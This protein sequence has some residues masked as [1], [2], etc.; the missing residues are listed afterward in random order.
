MPANPF[1][2]RRRDGL[3]Q[4]GLRHPVY[5]HHLA[6]ALN[7]PVWVLLPYAPDWRWLLGRSDSPWYPSMRL[8]RQREPKQWDGVFREV[9][10]ALRETA[11]RH[12]AEQA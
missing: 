9:V 5:A 1:R 6:G 4:F 2:I 3:R 7:R 12:E 10:S 8:F 11:A